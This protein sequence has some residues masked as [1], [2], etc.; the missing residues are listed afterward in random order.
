MVAGLGAR[1]ANAGRDENH[2]LADRE[3]NAGRFRRA[4]HEP[5][6]AERL[7]LFRPPAH[8]LD[9]AETVPSVENVRVVVGRQDRDREQ[10]EPRALGARDRGAHRLRI[11][12]N[13]EELGAESGRLRRRPLDGVGNVVQLEIEK[14]LTAGGGEPA[15]ER[16]AFFGIGKLHA[17][18]IEGGGVADALDEPLGLADIGHI[19]RDDEPVARRERGHRAVLADAPQTPSRR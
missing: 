13:G 15:R 4:R 9:H 14:N 3:A 8:Q 2:G 16:K 17:D 5:V 1:R 7:S 10:L 11:G 12:M 6:D 18:L 19:E